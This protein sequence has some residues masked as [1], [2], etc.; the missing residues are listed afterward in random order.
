[1]KKIVIVTFQ[2]AYN[3]GA[4][5]QCYALQTILSKNKNNVEVLNYDNET[6]SNVYKTFYK[7]KGSLKFLK[8]IKSFVTGLMYSKQTIPRNRKFRKFIKNNIFLTKKMNQKEIL[9]LEFKKDTTLVVGSDQVWNTDITNGYDPIYM[10]DFGGNIKRVSYAASIGKNLIDSKYENKIKKTLNKYFAI[11]V[12]EKTAKNELV[13]FLDKNIEVTLDPTL[14]IEKDEWEKN[15]PKK[16]KKYENYIFVYMPNKECEKIAKH[17][18]DKYNKKIVYIDKKNIFNKNSINISDADPFDFLSYI[19][20]A[21]YVVTTSFHATIFSIIFNKK[22]WIALPKTV[23]S[24][25]TDLLS[26]L[27]ISNRCVT[28]YYEFKSKN[29][30][31]KIDYDEVNEILKEKRKK[32]I[33]WLNKHI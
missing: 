13:K 2:N 5:L 19:K 15:V 23:G 20:H 12:R 8:Y 3:Y 16:R 21:D 9:N 11:S 31:E 22:I 10:L 33:D 4:I 18:Q 28:T 25:I 26:E 29:P 24:R 32:S 14:L 27:N 7:P 30:D 17:L 1:M 6:I